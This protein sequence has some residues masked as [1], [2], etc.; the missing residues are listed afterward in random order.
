MKRIGILVLSIALVAGAIVGY[1]YYQENSK[2]KPE[3]GFTGGISIDLGKDGGFTGKI[4]IDE[5]GGQISIE[6]R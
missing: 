3:P 4:K 2:P 6:R 5:K 1:H